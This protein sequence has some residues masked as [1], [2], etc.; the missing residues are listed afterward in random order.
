MPKRSGKRGGRRAWPLAVAVVAGALAL[1]GGLMA[2]RGGGEAYRSFPNY[3]SFT[4]E[5]LWRAYRFAASPQGEVLAYIP[6]Y[7]GCVY[8][9][10][11][12]NRDCYVKRQ[13][14]EGTVYDSHAAGCSVC[15]AITLDVEAL[16]QQG[17]DLP[18]IRR[19]ID[20]RYGGLGPGTPTPY[21]GA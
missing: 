14:E 8:H 18:S 21:P 10:H 19:A 11:R 12:D 7:C 13:T 3:T 1:V 16:L 17:A 20:N 4:N 15:V 2:L 5:E 6:C 9:G